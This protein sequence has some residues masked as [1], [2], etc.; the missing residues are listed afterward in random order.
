MS[1]HRNGYLIGNA[2]SSEVLR[3]KSFKGKIALH[4]GIC[5]AQNLVDE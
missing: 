2:V 1:Q 3:N 5:F 4:C